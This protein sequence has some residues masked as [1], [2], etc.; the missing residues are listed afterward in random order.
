MKVVSSSSY[1]NDLTDFLP[2][3]V[4]RTFIL[5]GLSEIQ[6]MD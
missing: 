3:P 2:L 5:Y 6:R 4:Q 1:S